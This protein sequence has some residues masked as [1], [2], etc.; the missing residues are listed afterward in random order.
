MLLSINV[1]SAFAI[2]TERE[3]IHWLSAHWFLR[4][5]IAP[6]ADASEQTRGRWPSAATGTKPSIAVKLLERALSLNLDDGHDRAIINEVLAQA[7][8]DLLP[9]F[10]QPGAGSQYALDFNKMNIAPVK[11]AYLCPVSRRLTDTVFRGLSPY[12]I[13]TSSRF[14]GDAAVAFTMPV[15]PNPFLLS[16]KGGADIVHEW[17]AKDP[18]IAKLRD[19][20][21]WTNLHDRIALELLISAPRSIP[22]SNHRPVFASTRR[23]SKKVGS[24]C[25]TARRP[26]RW[27]STSVG[28]AVMMTNVPPSVA[29]YRQ[30]VG[31]A[32]RHGQG[33][34]LA[35]TYARTTPLDL[36]T[37]RDPVGYLVDALKPPG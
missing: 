8:S 32:G 15:H 33:F 9:L 37:F 30:R 28:L 19:R 35:L 24:T 4:N 18:H 13:G 7:W 21:L 22:R 20:R 26:W 17:L 27:A 25:S 11:T 12:G 5:L 36:E 34:A 1:R 3:N 6:G 14:S 29:N 16:D 10:A 23:S 2:R 31:R